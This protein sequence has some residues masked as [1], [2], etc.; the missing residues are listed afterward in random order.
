[1]Q[2]LPALVEILSRAGEL[3]IVDVYDE[4]EF[5]AWVKI[6]T[7]PGAALDKAFGRHVPFTVL[8]PVTARIRVAI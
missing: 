2:K 4:E 3:E 7:A 5:E 8:F 6:A 1:M